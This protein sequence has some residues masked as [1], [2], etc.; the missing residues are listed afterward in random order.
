MTQDNIQQ[1]SS[2]L[3]QTMAQVAALDADIAVHQVGEAALSTVPAS[4]PEAAAIYKST[5]LQL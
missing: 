4:A 5:N 3:T 2:I 1:A